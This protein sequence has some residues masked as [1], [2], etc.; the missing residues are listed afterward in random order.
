MPKPQT[1]QTQTFP[2]T[3]QLAVIYCRV[4]SIKQTTQGS[5][6]TSQEARCR[7]YAKYKGYGVVA[8][9]TDDMSGG[10]SARPGMLEMLSFLRKHR[11]APHVVIIDDIS[12]LARGLEAHLQLRADISGAGGRLE[13]PSI[14]FGED[15]DSILVEN[16]LA[17]VAQHQREKNGEQTRNRMRARIMSGYW[18]FKAPY[19]YRYERKSGHGNLLVRDEPLASIIQDALE[20]YACG[21]FASQAEVKRFFEDQPAFPKCLPNGEIRQQRVTDILTR[22]T[23]AGYI[24]VPEWDISLRKGQHDGLVSFATWKKV[25]E[26]LSG[27]TKAPFRKDIAEDFPLRGFVACGDC[28]KTMTSCW[29]KGSTK[30]YPYY[31]C[32]TKGC[33][34]YRK[35]IRRADIEEGFESILRN[36]TPSRNLLSAARK[37]FVDLW[38]E[39]LARA[40]ADEQ[41]LRKRLGEIERQSDALLVRIVETESVPVITAYEKKIGA[42][43]EEKLLVSEKLENLIPPSGTFE[44]LFELAWR[45]L[46]NPW[47]IWE[48]EVLHLRRLVLRLTFAQQL[49]YDRKTGYRTPELSLPFKLLSP[50]Q[51]P[52]CEMVRSRRLELPRELPHSDLNAA[53]LPFR[54][55]RT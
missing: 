52:V 44:N 39:R 4:S 16:L 53:R 36:M 10:S 49:V 18:C 33:S 19:G 32:D 7:E 12:R 13:S 5:G 40:E 9:F 29:S 34:S 8:V 3:D 47:K 41:E 54:H 30:S 25:Q 27:K 2:E 28:G 38:D 42:L 31:L 23:Y 48:S 11:R 20:G 24:E 17:S 22:A 50:S 46:S 6:L 26:K 37:M 45:F 35:S 15:S 51:T 14:E 43:S 21:C 1:S 55:D